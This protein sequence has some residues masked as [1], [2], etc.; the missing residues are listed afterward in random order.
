V[1]SGCSGVAY[2][3]N[4][5]VADVVMMM[6]GRWLF[7]VD[8]WSLWCWILRLGDCSDSSAVAVLAATAMRKQYT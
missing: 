8:Y 5:R 1:A 7:G 6:I 3:V 2:F 4:S